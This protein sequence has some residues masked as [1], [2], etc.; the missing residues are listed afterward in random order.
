MTDIFI[1]YSHKDEAWKNELQ[2]HLKVLRHHGNITIWDDRQIV[3]GDD[4]YPAIQSAIEN[5]RVAILLVSR[6]FLNSDFVSREEIPPLLERRKAGGLKVMPLIV[7]PCS[8]QSVPWLARLQGATK[9]IPL[10]P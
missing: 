6:D 9:R 5:A 4:W 7:R 2:E 10:Y 8:W 3:S 1:S